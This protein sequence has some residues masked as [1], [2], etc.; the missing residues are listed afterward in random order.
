MEQSLGCRGLGVS[1]A[2]WAV[3]LQACCAF[4]GLRTAPEALTFAW[5]LGPRTVLAERTVCNRAG[6]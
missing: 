5:T 4:T 1:S 2:S 3:S 6:P